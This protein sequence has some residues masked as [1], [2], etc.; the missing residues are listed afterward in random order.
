MEQARL[1]NIMQRLW[2]QNTAS[3]PNRVYAVL[4]G[5]RDTQIA[6]LVSNSQRPHDCLYYPPLSD[7]LYAAAPHIV[8][9]NAQAAF[10]QQLLQRAW[11]NSWGI[12]LVT[13][14]F[15]NLATVRHTCRKLN[16]VLGAKGERLLFR[17]YDPRVMRNYLPTC[18]HD[19]V[20]TVFGP[21][22]AMVMEGEQAALLHRFQHNEQGNKAEVCRV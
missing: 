11:G 2:P 16:I 13:D 5:A 10:T 14:S 1:D 3:S 19:E 8:E 12:F 9:L 22:K 18:T 4:D 6:P 7:A 21:I 15:I 17:Y 20:N